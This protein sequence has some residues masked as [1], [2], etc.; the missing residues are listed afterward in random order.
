MK[1]TF[2]IVLCRHLSKNYLIYASGYII[3][4]LENLNLNRT[5]R[6]SLKL[7]AFTPEFR[8]TFVVSELSSIFAGFTCG[9]VHSSSKN[10]KKNSFDSIN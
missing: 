6:L 2:I 1:I 9:V 7:A 8:L 4:K 10:E 3:T 5:L